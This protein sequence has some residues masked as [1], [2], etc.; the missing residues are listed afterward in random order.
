MSSMLLYLTE[1]YLSPAGLPPPPPPVETP[2][3]G[4][5]HPSRPGHYWPNPAAYMSWCGGRVAG[6]A[7]EAVAGVAF[8]GGGEEEEEERCTGGSWGLRQR[9]V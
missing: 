1:Q 7:F 9:I 5:L 2:Q 3:T 8:E 6:V 4:C